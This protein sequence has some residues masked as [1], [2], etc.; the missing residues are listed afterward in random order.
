MTNITTLNTTV[1]NPNDLAYVPWEIWAVLFFLTFIFFFHAIIAQK[2]TDI[3]A[4]I[5]VILAGVTAWISGFIEFSYVE[6]LAVNN[7]TNVVPVSYI[8]HPTWLSY[9]MLGVFF[10]SIVI[11]WKNVYEIYFLK[12]KQYKMKG[13]R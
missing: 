1:I 6:T 3:T 10:V 5:T 9:I 2:N 11:A 13:F 4:V 8:T 12:E 7:T